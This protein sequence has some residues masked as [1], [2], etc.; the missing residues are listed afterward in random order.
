MNTLYIRRIP[1]ELSAMPSPSVQHFVQIL[2]LYTD[3]QLCSINTLPPVCTA[4]THGLIPVSDN[5]KHIYH[6][7]QCSKLTHN[8]GSFRWRFIVDLN[9]SHMNMKAT[10]I[11]TGFFSQSFHCL[12][13]LLRPKDVPISTTQVGHQTYTSYNYNLHQ[14]HDELITTVN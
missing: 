12:Y 10:Q 2:H 13:C 4:N 1:A 9:F 8:T 7:I 11:P 14:H 5:L 3:Q 6:P